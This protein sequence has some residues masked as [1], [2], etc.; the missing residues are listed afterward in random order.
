[1]ALWVILVIVYMSSIVS[2]QAA[3]S[4]CPVQWTGS[5]DN[6]YRYF[7]SPLSYTDAMEHCRYL[8]YPGRIASLATVGNFKELLFISKFIDDLFSNGIAVPSLIWLNI[9]FINTSGRYDIDM[10]SICMWH[11]GETLIRDG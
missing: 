7:S 3:C 1:M 2:T 5:R 6:C 11:L 10:K 4:W 9:V 8:S